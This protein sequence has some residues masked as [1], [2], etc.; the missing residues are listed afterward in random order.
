M[1]SNMIKIKEA[2]IVEGNYD[3]I[4]LSSIVDTMIICTNGFQVFKD[5]EKIALIRA[6]AEKRGIIVFTDSDRAGFIIR[7]Y[8][9]QSIAKEN[10][11]HA[12]LPDIFGKEKRK[13]SPSKEGKIGVEG[14]DKEVIISALKNAGA[15][16]FQEDSPTSSGASKKVTKLDLYNDGF[17][18]KDGSVKARREL[19][20]RLSLPERMSANMLV[21][22]I[23]SIMSYEEY[24]KAA[25]EITIKK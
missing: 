5:S 24:K 9:K 10:I 25:D 1:K 14:V 16:F 20:L 7:N 6:I 11:K 18:G 15:T 21:D 12:Y 8:V 13:T 19:L 17:F 3:K 4:K 22:A 2:I 23:N